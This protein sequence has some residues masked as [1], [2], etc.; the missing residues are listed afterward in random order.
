MQSTLLGIAIA[1]IVALVAALVGPA[2]I[3]WGYY[4]STFEGELTHLVGLPV[5]VTGGIDARLLPTPTVSLRGIVIKG[6]PGQSPKLSAQS[7]DVELALGPLM[8]GQLRAAALR[9]GQPEFTV[10]LD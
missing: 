8:R 2:F 9:V 10:G 4:R 6:P 1:I 3:D 7:L 5:Q